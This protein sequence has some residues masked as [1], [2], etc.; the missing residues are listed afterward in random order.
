MSVF[1][2]FLKFLEAPPTNLRLAALPNLKWAA[3]RSAPES[4]C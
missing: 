4:A 1:V 3:W 2:E